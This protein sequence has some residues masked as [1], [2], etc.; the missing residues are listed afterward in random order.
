VNYLEA[1]AVVRAVKDLLDDPAFLSD[2][3]DWYRHQAVACACN[4]ALA[5]PIERPVASTHCPTIAVIA[6]Y[7]AQVE[8][9]RRLLEVVVAHA[10]GFVRIQAGTPTDFLQRECLIALVSL[11]RSHTHRAVPFGEGPQ[12]L[13]LALTRAARRVWIFGDPGTLARRCQ[14]SGP[15]DHLDEGA[16]ERERG[17]LH[18]LVRFY[19]HQTAPTGSRSLEGSG[20]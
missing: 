11:T 3:D 1:R 6:L 13:A 20:V 9:L 7:P 4:P 5:G 8:L 17:L 18:R 16:A 12:Q 2:A 19:Q 10:P 15:L 14:W